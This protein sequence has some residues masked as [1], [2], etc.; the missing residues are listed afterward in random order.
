M[1]LVVKL[2]E[3]D[4]Q[5]Q[6]ILVLK[7]VLLHVNVVV[8]QLVEQV[9][10]DQLLGSSSQCQRLEKADKISWPGSIRQ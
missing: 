2:V 1:N 5:D 3:Q 6:L 7:P 9:R 8:K 10:Q 4:R